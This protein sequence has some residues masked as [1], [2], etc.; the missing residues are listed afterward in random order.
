MPDRREQLPGDVGHQQ[1]AAGDEGQQRLAG[2]PPRAVDDLAVPG[3]VMTGVIMAMVMVMPVIVAGMVMLLCRR[4]GRPGRSDLVAQR[5]HLPLDGAPGDI[6]GAGHRHRAVGKRY[7]DLGDARQAAD[8]VLDL[9]GA[10]GAIHAANTEFQ[11]L[12]GLGHA[13]LLGFFIMS[14]YI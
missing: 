13:A 4:C 14:A 9:G 11:L 12:C 1:R 8:G 7:A 6:A 3:V 2:L 10:C 5:L